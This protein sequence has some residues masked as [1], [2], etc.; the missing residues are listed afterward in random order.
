MKPNEG[1]VDRIIRLILGVIFLI[2]GFFVVGT[3]V[4]GVILDIIGVIL[5]VTALTGFCVLY[6]FFGIS[7]KK[8]KGT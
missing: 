2:L 8:E 7:T 1:I 5:V 3:G 4:L 6:T